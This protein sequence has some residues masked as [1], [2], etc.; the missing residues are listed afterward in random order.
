MSDNY[1]CAL[2]ADFSSDQVIDRS[3]KLTCKHFINFFLRIPIFR[4]NYDSFHHITFSRIN[5][6]FGN[7]TNI[8]S[9]R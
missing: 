8:L 7:K 3:S 2:S 9:N 4:L 5:F 1:K 6:H